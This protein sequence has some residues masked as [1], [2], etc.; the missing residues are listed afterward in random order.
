MEIVLY[1]L[2]RAGGLPLVILFN[3]LVITVA[4]GLLLRTS[5]FAAGG[6]LRWAALATL[7]AAVVGLGNW[8][9]RP[10]TASILFFALALYLLEY[11]Q[12]SL[13]DGGAGTKALWW[14]VPQG[15]KSRGRA[16]P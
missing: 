12:R 5:Q 9:V 16:N 8:N 6:N 10:Q 15:K 14:L 7:A 4:Y 2:L 13:E 3:A 11:R 1:L